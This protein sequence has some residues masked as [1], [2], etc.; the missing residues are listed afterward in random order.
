LEEP[1]KSLENL[2][3]P[4]KNPES[5]RSIK[6]KEKPLTKLQEMIRKMA[7]RTNVKKVDPLIVQ[8][9]NFLKQNPIIPGNIYLRQV[10]S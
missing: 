6:K 1:E 2:A 5:K 10:R 8:T 3:E 4:K 7:G 9:Q